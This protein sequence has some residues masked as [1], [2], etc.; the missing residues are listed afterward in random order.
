LSAQESAVSS[1]PSARTAL[2]EYL[3]SISAGLADLPSLIAELERWKAEWRA[4]MEAARQVSAPDSIAGGIL[5]TKRLA[6]LWGMPEAKIRALCRA[7]HLPARKLGP[8]EW[9]IPT[10]ALRA[11]LV[12][13]P[14]AKDVSPGL[15]SPPHDT[16]RGPPAPQATRPYTVVVRRPAGDPQ[17]HG[18]EVGGG[19]EGDERHDGAVAPRA[20]HAGRKGAHS[21]ASG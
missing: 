4:R 19:H 21:A 9:V 15:T 16:G 14:L 20:R 7:G 13:T 3:A 17:D 2:S 12:T 1:S 8:K 10:D 11:W 6:D 5:T 18:G